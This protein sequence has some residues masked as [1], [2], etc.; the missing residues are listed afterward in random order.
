MLKGLLIHGMRHGHYSSVGTPGLIVV[1]QKTKALC[2][3]QLVDAMGPELTNAQA[4]GCP[5][6]LRS[7]RVSKR[8]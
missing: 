4:L 5:L 3:E 8:V 2:L 7:V 6:G 1:L